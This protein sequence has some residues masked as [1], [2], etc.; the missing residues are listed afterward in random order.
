MAARSKLIY[1]L[2]FIVLVGYLNLISSFQ[3]GFI[4]A[5]YSSW[6]LCLAD[7]YHLSIV[8]LANDDSVVLSDSQSLNLSA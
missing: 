3:N 7:D 4:I 8:L 2:I 5:E 6:N 1:K